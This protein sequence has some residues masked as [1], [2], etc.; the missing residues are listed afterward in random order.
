MRAKQ[1]A[2]WLLCVAALACQVALILSL[3]LYAAF[4][5]ISHG[6]ASV[7]AVVLVYVSVVVLLRA[8]KR[9][10]RWYRYAP[11]YLFYG[12]IGLFVPNVEGNEQ[13]AFGFVGILP[14]VFMALMWA[15]K[16]YWTIK[17]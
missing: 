16:R 5:Q 7:V 9:P 4:Y 8:E 17:L 14:L 15:V 12:V 3:R 13:L 11:L 6:I 10:H 2:V 1:F